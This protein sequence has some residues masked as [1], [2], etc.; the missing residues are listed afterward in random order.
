MPSSQDIISPQPFRP[1]KRSASQISDLERQSTRPIPS[2]DSRPISPTT[3]RLFDWVLAQPVVFDR[4]GSRSDSFLLE[5]ERG[6]N[7]IEAKRQPL[8]D[9]V[10]QYPKSETTTSIRPDPMSKLSTQDRKYCSL[11]LP[12]HGIHVASLPNEEKPEVMDPV[13]KRFLDDTIRKPRD[14]TTITR[15]TWD[16][17]VLE[18]A[19]DIH[20]ESEQS[21][22]ADHVNSPMFPRKNV[23]YKRTDIIRL[24]DVPWT[25]DPLPY[26][27]KAETHIST[28]EPDFFWS[29]IFAE[30]ISDARLLTVVQDKRLVNYAVPTG[31]RGMFP[32][33]M[34]EAKA[35]AM[36]MSSTGAANEGAGSGVHSVSTMC[37]LYK[38]ARNFDK[39]LIPKTTDTLAFVITSDQDIT[40][41]WVTYWSNERQ[42]YHMQ[43]FDNYSTMKHHDVN[44]FRLHWKNILDWALNV[45]LPEIKRLLD[46]I[47]TDWVDSKGKKTT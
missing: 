23:D 30:T 18:E 34:L 15:E 36:K 14:S 9:T 20:N 43:K 39:S 31:G 28:P 10:P 13:V 44:R 33:L 7:K 40:S 6:N 5:L 8:E 19:A 17:D 25:R 12:F 42:S 45:R 4:K 24:G 38:H 32:F 2:E 26:I 37:E 27:A 35:I 47:A 22:I 41:L 29:Y 46:I 16:S 3:A 21:V 1:L 11:V